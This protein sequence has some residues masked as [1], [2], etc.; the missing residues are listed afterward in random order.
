MNKL[1]VCAMAVAALL[2]AVVP[3]AQAATVT[4]AFTVSVQLDGKCV[5]TNNA[6]QTLNFGT[7]TAFGSATTPSPTTNLTFNCTRGL[8]SPTFSFDTINGTSTGYGV[9]AGLNYTLSTSGSVTTTGTAATAASAPNG[10]ADVYTVVIT[11]DM[12]TGQAGQCG[13]AS[14][15]AAACDGTAKTHTRT[16]T[17]SY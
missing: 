10:T 13:T 14:S 11:G 2:T 4:S 5:A 17:V 15:A 12:P 7:Y 6:T 3:A 16:L 1:L 9:L 8:A